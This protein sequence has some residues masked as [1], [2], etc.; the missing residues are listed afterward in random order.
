MIFRDRLEALVAGREGSTLDLALEEPPEGWTGLCGRLEP[1]TLGP[2]LDGLGEGSDRAYYLCGPEPMM[3]AAR[4]LL[5]S[6]GVAPEAIFEERFRSPQ[7]AASPDAR[8]PTETVT[9]RVRAHGA[10]TIVPVPPGQTLLEAGLAAGVA[11]PFSCAMGGCAACKCRLTEG[12]VAMEEPNCLSAAER[13]EGWVLACAAR[14]L[15][16]A[17]LEVL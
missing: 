3:D 15:G 2:W 6:R 10:D 14:P 7:D 17:R 11:M 8:L 12:E 9:V 1:S 13:E 4:D 5:L 16:P